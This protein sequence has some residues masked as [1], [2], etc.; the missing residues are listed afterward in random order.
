MNRLRTIKIRIIFILTTALVYFCLDYFILRTSFLKCYSFVGLKSFIPMVVGL[1]FGPYGVIGELIAI[2]VKAKLTNTSNTF[3]IMECI[4]VIIIG[5]GTWF[6]WHF[7][8]R[9]HRIRL[10]YASN[11]IRYILIIVFLSFICAIISLKLIN[12][13][14]FED[15]MGWNISMS[16]LVGI[17]VEIIY[18]SLMNIDP[19]LPPITVNGKPI[20]IKNDIEYTVDSDSLTFAL[21]NEKLEELLLK[22]NLDMKRVF[23]MQ[24]VVEEMYLRIIKKYPKAVIDIIVN[25]DI[26][27][28][29]EYIYIGEKC[30]PFIV[31]KEED[32]FDI[33]GL[34]IIKHRALLAR[35]SYNYGLNKVNIVI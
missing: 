29:I 15:I 3:Y 33:V 17:P 35:Y 24:N 9:T 7:Q 26:T 6:L 18:S 27:F 11:Y 22:R 32:K 31:S 4:I 23:E 25:I 13:Y 16:I 2:S 12:F 8:S 5:I 14:A 28:S 1:N 10:R 20:E 34:N 30:N 19:I 21:F